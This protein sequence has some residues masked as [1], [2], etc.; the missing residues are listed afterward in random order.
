VGLLFLGG[1]LSFIYMFQVYQ[2]DHWSR[3]G[4]SAPP[5]PRAARLL[6]LGVAV[7]VLALGLWPEPLLL[8]SQRAAAILAQEGP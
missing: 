5:S 4:V 3:D 7:V 2:R 8:A 6:V 1:A